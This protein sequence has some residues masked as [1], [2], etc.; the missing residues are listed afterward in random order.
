M[1]YVTIDVDVDLSDFDSE[2]LIGELEARGE[3][4]VSSSSTAITEIVDKI[5]Q[6][7]RTGGDYQAELDQLIYLVT[8]KIL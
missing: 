2:D 4:I 3:D 5:W 8:G 7:R 6:S 1:P